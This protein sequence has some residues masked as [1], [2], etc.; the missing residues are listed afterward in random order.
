[1]A[2]GTETTGKL[3]AEPSKITKPRTGTSNHSAP[4]QLNIIYGS[5]EH[6]LHGL[7]VT[8]ALNEDGIRQLESEDKFLF[9]P[10]ASIIKCLAIS[11]PDGNLNRR[12]LATGGADD[13]INLYSIGGGSN[14]TL[15]SLL[16]H[17]RAITCLAFSANKKLFSAAEDNTIA[18]SRPKDW[19]VL[20]T[21]KA[22]LPKAQGRPSG[23]T[24]RIDDLPAGINSFAIHPD[25]KLMLSVGRGEKCIRTW[26][27]TTG[28][29]AGVLN[30]SKKILESVGLGK[31][32]RKEGIAVAWSEKGSTFCIAFETG[33]AV[34]GLDAKLKAVALP[35]PRTKLHSMTVLRKTTLVVSTEDGRVLFFRISDLPAEEKAE[36]VRLPRVGYMGGRENGVKSRIKCVEIVDVDSSSFLVVAAGSDGTI[37]I[38]HITYEEL[39]DG[40]GLIGRGLGS[41]ETGNRI[42]CLGAYRDY[43]EENEDDDGDSKSQD[44]WESDLGPPSDASEV[45][46]D[47][48]FVRRRKKRFWTP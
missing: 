33:I 36:L 34:M 1:M 9:T 46:D 37:R 7:T 19:T 43:S 35:E 18:I 21:L 31:F 47:Y 27:L 40:K 6:V 45:L 4:V 2:K 13:K 39:K 25:Q 24:A 11:P 48:T 32:D 14:K 10:H 29:K 15:G 23:D 30:F 16:H 22:P 42:T 3:E 38:W 28:E 5:Y 26:D 12:I 8:V 20:S 44:E 17:D 41:I